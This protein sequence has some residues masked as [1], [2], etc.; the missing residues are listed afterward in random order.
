MGTP[1]ISIQNA[2]IQQNKNVVLDKVSLKIDAGAFVYFIGRT[3][4]GKSS[5]I[6]T[7]YAALPLKSGEISICDTALAKLKTLFLRQMAKIRSFANRPT[8]WGPWGTL[9]RRRAG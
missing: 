6:R 9:L 1:I 8:P 3:G 2:A 5:L 7:L 4:S